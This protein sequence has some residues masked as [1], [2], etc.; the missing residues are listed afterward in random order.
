MV[1]NKRASFE[2]TIYVFVFVNL[3]FILAGGFFLLLLF[4]YRTVSM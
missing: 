4:N 1:S 2:Y 3:A